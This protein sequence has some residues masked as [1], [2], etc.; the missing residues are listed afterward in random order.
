[1]P[2]YLSR[3]AILAQDDRTYQD[4]KV[5]EWAGVVRVRS[6]TGAE[7]DQWEAACQEEKQG[8]KVFST[9]KLREKLLSF[10]LVDAAGTQLF[11]EGDIGLLAEK[12]AAALTR[13]FGVAMKLNAIG[14]QDVEEL[15]GNSGAGQA[16]SSTSASP[17]S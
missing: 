2:K 13:L 6:L 17:E 7:R 4:V 11:S 8:Q 12:N 15:V 5:R 10:C 1:M 3:E 9:D 14:A 16:G